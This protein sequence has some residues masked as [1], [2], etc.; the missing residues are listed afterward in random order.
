[1][2]NANQCTM[3]TFSDKKNNIKKQEITR[4]VKLFL[5]FWVSEDDPAKNL[6]SEAAKTRLQNIK[7]SSWYSD[8]IHKVYTLSIQNLDEIQLIINK[9]ILKY[10]SLG[11]VKIAELGIFSHA[12]SDG[13][14]IYSGTPAEPIDPNYPIQITLT[15]WNKLLQLKNWDKNAKC[16]FYGCNTA[17]ENNTQDN[18]IKSFAKNISLLSNFKDVEIAGQSTSSYLSFLPDKRTTSLSRAFDIGWS[19]APTYLV[20]SNANTGKDALLLG[21]IVNPMHFYINGRKTKTSHQG[22]F[23]DHRKNKK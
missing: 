12:A 6:F 1:M 2:V 15:A 5:L 11:D 21:A 19:F 17:R 4:K 14:I 22:I 16:I 9:Y 10:S 8:Q 3:G 7:N 18:T 20:A 23:N 13:P